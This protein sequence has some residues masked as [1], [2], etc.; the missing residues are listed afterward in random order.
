M[1]PIDTGIVFAYFGL[2]IALG[3]V[4]SRKQHSVEDFFLAGGKIG[5]FSVGCLWL[6]SYIGGASIIGGSA[7]AYEIGYSGGWYIATMAIG[8]ILFAA[9]FAVRVKRLGNEN[10][11]LTYPDFIESGYDSRTRIVA[12]VTTAAAFIGYAAGQLAA[13]AAILSALLG[14]DYA[15]SLLLS[16]AVIIVYTATGGFLAVTYT[17]WVQVSILV[18]GIV[19]IGIPIAIMNGGTP[20]NLVTQLGDTH[21]DPLGWGLAEMA[22]LGVS[23]PLSFFVA[24][25]SYTRMFAARDEKSGTI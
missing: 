8:C 6:A 9:F 7:K 14:W 21:F 12:T 2:M 18:V 24:M 4:A 3:I 19:F 16:S 20:E 5:A 15:T 23:I 11:F 10:K 1:G 25:D 22:A 13:A 17:D